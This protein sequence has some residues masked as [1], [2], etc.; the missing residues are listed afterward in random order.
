VVGSQA[1]ASANGGLGVTG[2]AQDLNLAALVGRD[3]VS[4][5]DGP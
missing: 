1:K 5:G 4:D 3:V 2:D